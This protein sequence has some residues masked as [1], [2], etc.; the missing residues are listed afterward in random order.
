M[1]LALVYYFVDIVGPG[2][3]IKGCFDEVFDGITASDLLREYL[4]NENSEKSGIY[5]ENEKKE[6]IFQIFRIF[7][8]GGSLCQPDS[9][10]E[11]YLSITKDFYK[12]LVT[13]YRWLI[14]IY[15]S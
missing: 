7:V 2:G 13:V 8:I 14:I 10:I 9:S 11:R 5:S 15:I 12:E 6:L 3:R 1:V 4:L